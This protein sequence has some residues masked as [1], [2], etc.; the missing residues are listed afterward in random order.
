MTRVGRDKREAQLALL[1]WRDSYYRRDGLVRA[2]RAA[3]VS[4]YRIHL[5]TGIARSTIDRILSPAK[6]ID[7]P[8]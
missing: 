2:A 7:Y 4:K 5:I 8:S 1:A 3:G 6:D